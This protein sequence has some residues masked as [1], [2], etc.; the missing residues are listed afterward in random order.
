MHPKMAKIS[1][2][3]VNGLFLLIHTML[4]IYFSH[5]D[6]HAMAYINVASILL[7]L[8]GFFLI[9]K[10][11][12]RVFVHVTGI[13]V[14]LHMVIAAMLL[15]T[16]YGFQLCLFGVVCLFF[17]SDYFSMKKEGRGLHGMQLSLAAFAGYVVSYL[18]SWNVKP[19][20]EINQTVQHVTF[21]LIAVFIFVVV[22]IAMSVMTIYAV[23]SEQQ[24]VKKAD[25]DALTGLP[26]RYSMLE[27]MRKIMEQEDAQNY[28]LAMIDIDNFKS[29]NDT[30]GH[31]IGDEVLK[32]LAKT[33]T[34]D[35][36]IIPC[37]WGG[38]E[39]LIV[40]HKDRDGEVPVKLLDDLR[41]TIRAVDMKAEDNFFH[42]TVTMGVAEYKKGSNLEEWVEVADKKLYVG[43]YN[44]KNRVVV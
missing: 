33:L 17:Y 22:I 39:F 44:G 20:Y 40:G 23:N 36:E 38:E 11:W 19:V 16:G 29:I 24:L 13:E 9:Y 4:F 35:K 37:R 6:I 31:N 18:Y 43:K 21:L 12:L 10:D 15:G 8:I 1:A 7:Y 42:I 26:N 3:V 14:I 41:H 28:W 25:F 5:F 2:T 32:M 27:D 34:K 30:Y